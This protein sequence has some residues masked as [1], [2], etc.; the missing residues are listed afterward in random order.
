M[1]KTTPEDRILR[2]DD[3]LVSL[4]QSL[5]NLRQQAEDLR[6]SIK[7]GGEAAM[8]EKSKELGRA[9]VVI[10]HCQK[11]EACL[12]EQR[13]RQAGIVQ[14][15]HALDL[16]RARFEIGCRLARIRRCGDTGEFPE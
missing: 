16:E 15:G 9:D 12:V 3:L 6:E 5:V 14:G 1:A 10:R 7:A 8:A 11:V 13:E 4:H 2:T